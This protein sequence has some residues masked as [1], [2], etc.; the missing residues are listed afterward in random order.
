M[1]LF[2]VKEG[3]KMRCGYTTGSCAAAAAKA[4]AIMVLT[5]RRV[6]AISLQT[7]QGTVL[8]L[9][10][11]EVSFGPQSATCAIRKDSGDDPD[12]T[13][14]MLVYGTVEKTPSGLSIVGGIGV[15][16]VTQPG[17]ACAVGDWAINPVPRRMI[18]EALQ[19]ACR[20]CGYT[21]GLCLTLSI[22]EG[23]RLARKTFNPR[24][25]IVG[26]LSILGTS[27]IVDPMSEQAL[28]DTI[29]T[30][31]D[32]RRAAGQTHLL[33]F[34]GNYGVDFSRDH[35]GVDVS[36]RVT[37]SNYVGE[38]LDYAAY[39]GFS[40]VLVIGHIGKLVKV[41]QGIMNTHSHYADGRT[42]LLALEAVFAGAS[43]QL[44]RQIYDSL[45]TDEAVRLLKEQNLLEP[46][47]AA[48]CEKIEAYMDQRTHGEVPTA[49]VVFSNAYGV[50]G[51]TSRAKAF[52]ALHTKGELR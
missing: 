16:R 7:P 1:S 9:I 30:E 38:T 43:R 6:E 22:P 4:A 10:P 14:G 39:K 42:T 48:V 28:V 34:F 40:D 45:T 11:E 51:L 29:H 35:L 12:I 17:L 24:L 52:L 15:G 18:T 3:K 49:A 32:S 23:Q 31:M 5:G 33:A 25:G 26:G 2:T 13:D 41:A 19:A 44:A 47:M 8:Q 46:V 36:Q 50:L 27:G 37:I 21:G 20:L